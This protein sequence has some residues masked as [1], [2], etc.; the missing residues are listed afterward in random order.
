MAELIGKFKAE[1][2]FYGIKVR[3]SKGCDQEAN[4]AEVIERAGL[5]TGVFTG[6]L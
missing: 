1:G 5:I 4:E 2:L 3:V 6:V